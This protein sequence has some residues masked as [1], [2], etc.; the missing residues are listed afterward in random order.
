[1]T[2]AGENGLE[3]RGQLLYD[4]IP[5]EST[6]VDLIADTPREPGIYDLRFGVVIVGIRWLPINAE[7]VGVIVR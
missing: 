4:L 3:G 6:A 5:R 7:A 2:D 1:M